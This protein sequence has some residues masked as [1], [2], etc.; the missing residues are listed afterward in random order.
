MKKDVRRQK[1]PKLRSFEDIEDL[2]TKPT[3]PEDLA[4]KPTKPEDLAA[5]PTRRL[6][7]CI[8]YLRRSDS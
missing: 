8:L 5:K 3:K 4:A 2:A 6:K 1:I 7:I